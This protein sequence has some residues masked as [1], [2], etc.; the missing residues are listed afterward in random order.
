MTR[1]P[2]QK[3]GWVTGTK[4]SGHPQWSTK[5][6][7]SDTQTNDN[8]LTH[9][10]KPQNQV[11]SVHAVLVCILAG[12]A[13]WNYPG[14]FY[15][16]DF[17][18]HSDESI[19]ACQCFLGYI[20]ADLLVAL[21]YGELLYNFETFYFLHRPLLMLLLTYHA[22]QERNG[23]A[24]F[25]ISSTTVRSSSPGDCSSQVRIERASGYWR[26]DTIKRKIWE[27]KQWS[28]SCLLFANYPAIFREV[29]PR[30]CFDRDAV[31]GS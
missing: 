13:V 15:T 24:G 21:Y 28:S 25:P 27:K 16:E 29:R 8:S 9:S 11:S 3:S 2:A 18:T 22:P 4:D 5:M 19:F 20:T 1:K 12:K 31:W 26:L 6:H 14:S 10:T 23:P 7:N 17:Y 30:L